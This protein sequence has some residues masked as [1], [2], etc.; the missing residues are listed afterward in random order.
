VG[1]FKIIPPQVIE[2]IQRRFNE[3]SRQLESPL[4]SDL[5]GSPRIDPSQPIV[6]QARPRDLYG[7]QE[8]EILQWAISCEV[9]N[10]N[11]YY[12]LLLIKEKAYKLFSER[13]NG[14]RPK[15][16]DS[17]YSPFHPLHPLYDLLSD[18]KLEPDPNEGTPP[19]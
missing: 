17:R 7:Q 5:S 4:P 8:Q 2:A 14:Q 9:N 18:L 10:F 19:S 1:P 16:P 3:V 6:G 12:P 11:F 13:T 15:G